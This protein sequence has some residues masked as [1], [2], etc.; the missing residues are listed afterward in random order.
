MSASPTRSTSAS[1]FRRRISTTTRSRNSSSV[2]GGLR[3]SPSRSSKPFPIRPSA[4]FRDPPLAS[5]EQN[6]NMDGSQMENNYQATLTPVTEGEW[7]GWSHY[8]GGDPF[9]DLAGPFYFKVG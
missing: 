7:A 9:E 2:S 6:V 3:A 8:P 5:Q 4:C 1:G